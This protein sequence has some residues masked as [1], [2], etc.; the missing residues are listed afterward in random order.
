M[1]RILDDNEDGRVT[2]DE[3]H[4]ILDDLVLII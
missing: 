3:I 1:Q 4:P 2:L